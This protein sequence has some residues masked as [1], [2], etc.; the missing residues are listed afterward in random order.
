MTPVQE[1]ISIV[2]AFGVGVVFGMVVLT[3]CINVARKHHVNQFR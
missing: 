3:A 1:A 2:G